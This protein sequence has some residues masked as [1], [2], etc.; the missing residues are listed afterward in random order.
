[1]RAFKHA[2]VHF[3]LLAEPDLKSLKTKKKFQGL[4]DG[5]VLSINSAVYIGEEFG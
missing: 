4:F 1:L 2:N 3:H 5:G